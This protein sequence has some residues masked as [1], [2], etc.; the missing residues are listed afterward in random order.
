MRSLCTMPSNDLMSF[1]LGLVDRALLHLFLKPDFVPLL[2]WN[3]TLA[4]PQSYL[5]DF[6]SFIA[7]TSN[8]CRVLIFGGCFAFS[9]SLSTSPTG[10]EPYLPYL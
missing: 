8:T 10:L 1:F 7:F 4:S 9:T 3:Q 6:E 5:H 2:A